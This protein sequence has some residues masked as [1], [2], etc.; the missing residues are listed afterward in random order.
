MATFSPSAHFNSA[1]LGGFLDRKIHGENTGIELGGQFAF[2]H[3]DI[4]FEPEKEVQIA[5]FAVQRLPAGSS[6]RFALGPDTEDI[7]IEIDTDAV[8]G[9]ARKF[10]LDRVVFLVGIDNKAGFDSGSFR[11][12]GGLG[13]G[14]A[15]SHNGKAWI[16]GAERRGT[17]LSDVFRRD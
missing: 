12:S 17:T 1:G 5:E 2:I 10:D 8:F 9:N 6:A 4:E 16:G 13:G 3:R 7:G 14:A 15:S 11:R